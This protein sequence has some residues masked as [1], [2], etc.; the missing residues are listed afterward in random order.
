MARKPRYTEEQIALALQQHHAGI[1]LHE[2]VR[3]YG[4]SQQTIYRWRNKYGELSPNEV[5]RLK[6]L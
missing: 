5:R 6:Q 2:I 1:P 4:I 3:K